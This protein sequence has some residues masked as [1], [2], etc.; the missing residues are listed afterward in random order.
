MRLIHIITIVAML[1]VSVASAQSQDKV[2]DMR[3]LDALVD[4]ATVASALGSILIGLLG[5]YIKHVNTQLNRLEDKLDKRLVVTE[6]QVGQLHKTLLREYHTK[7]DLRE[8]LGIT[9]RPLMDKLTSLS[10]DMDAVYREL[11]H[12]NKQR[13]HNNERID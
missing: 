6:E 8:M 3:H 7:E 10:S 5:W 9:L 12:A 11:L 2:A 4:W 13:G 1:S